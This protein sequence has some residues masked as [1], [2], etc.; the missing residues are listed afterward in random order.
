MKV[1]IAQCKRAFTIIE[2]MVASSILVLILFSIY[3]TWTSIMKASRVAMDA[4]VEVQRSRVAIRAVED[5]LITAQNFAENQRYYYFYTDTDDEDFHFMSL[6]SRLPPTF[7]GSGMFGDYTLR[8]VTF[9]VQEGQD[10]KMQLIMN[11]MPMLWLTNETVQPYPITLVRDL[12]LFILE[13]WDPQRGE[14]MADFKATNSLPRMMRVT[15]GWGHAP[16]KPREPAEIISRQIAIP[17]SAVT[18][19]IQRPQVGVGGGQP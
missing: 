5:A 18:G 14:W 17:A 15:I 8:R 6:V 10:G 12:S 7:P 1:A 19:E 2:V 3:S 13:F 16:N 4:A 11:Q 9:E